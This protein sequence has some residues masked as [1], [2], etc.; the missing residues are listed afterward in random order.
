MGAVLHATPSVAVVLHATLISVL[1]QLLDGAL[2]TSS[3]FSSWVSACPSAA[4]W[5]GT[6]HATSQT[7]RCHGPP[8]PSFESSLIIV[9]ISVF[10]MI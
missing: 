6:P 7:D 9:F 4:R 10:Q 3:I 5:R 2:P 8:P 1:K